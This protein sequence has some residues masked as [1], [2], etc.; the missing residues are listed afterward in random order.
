MINRATK[1]NKEHRMQCSCVRWFNYSF[2]KL[3]GKLFAVANGGKRDAITGKQLKDE[4]VVAGVSDLILLVKNKRYCGL[5]IEM[6]TPTGRQSTSQKQWQE[7]ITNTDDYKYII[8]R[9]FDEFMNEINDYLN[10]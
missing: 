6:K 9:S 5:L 7:L 4:G 2:P 1:L 3:R 10:N 8:V